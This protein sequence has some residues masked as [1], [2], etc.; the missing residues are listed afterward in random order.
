MKSNEKKLVGLLA[1]LFLAVVVVRVIPMLRTSYEEGLE[2]IDFLEQRIARLRL[3]IEEAP[4]I[5]D[6]EAQRQAEVE[7]LGELVFTGTDLN[8]IGTSVQR[9]L[10]QVV[11]EAGVLARSYK[12]PRLSE[13]EGWLMINQ[14]MDFTIEQENILK[15]L[16]LLENSKPRLHVT[17][18]SINRN[19][20]QYSGSITVIGFSK[21]Q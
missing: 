11:E 12:T 6:E 19:R 13:M 17:E 20:R 2:E 1:I 16:N 14:E 9:Q 8:L 15:F 21:Q 4:F 5:V 18:F 7:A 10:R 3:L